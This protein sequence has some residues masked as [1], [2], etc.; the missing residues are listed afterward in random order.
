ML[1]KQRSGQN[2]R[3]QSRNSGFISCSCSTIWSSK[4]GS[5]DPK[6]VNEGKC[7][8]K[9][10]EG[11]EPGVRT[12]WGLKPPKK[13]NNN[14]NRTEGAVQFPLHVNEA[15][16]RPVHDHKQLK[17]NIQGQQGPKTQP[18]ELWVF[19]NVFKHKSQNAKNIS[20]YLFIRL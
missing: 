7:Q 11:Q 20:I 12:H 9:T 10:Q 18:R 15:K 3:Q 17:H 2:Q 13:N 1:S 4:G 8:T 14:T 5:Y 19:S 16:V 6:G